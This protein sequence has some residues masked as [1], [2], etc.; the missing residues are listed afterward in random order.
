LN[1]INPL[2]FLASSFKD[3]IGL[4]VNAIVKR[5]VT[6]SNMIVETSTKQSFQGDIWFTSLRSDKSTDFYLQKKLH[7]KRISCILL[8]RTHIFTTSDDGSLCICQMSENN[9]DTKRY[10]SLIPM[11]F[12]DLLVLEEDL[13]WKDNRIK[14]LRIEVS[15]KI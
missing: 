8:S 13:R 10:K 4:P 1:L 9:I 7:S 5:Y 15:C 11:A 12:Q 2:L 3:D 14:D 6:N